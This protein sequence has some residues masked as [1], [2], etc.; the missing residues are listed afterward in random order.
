MT[1]P[2]AA[3]IGCGAKYA[4]GTTSSAKWLNRTPN[5]WTPFGSQ[6]KYHDSGFGI[7]CVS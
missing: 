4:N 3:A 1:S 2:A 5:L 6:W 7:G